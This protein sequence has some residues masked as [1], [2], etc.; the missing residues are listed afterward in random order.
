[1]E[2]YRETTTDVLIIGQ[3]AAGLRTAIELTKNEISCL[4]LSKR[5]Y[6]DAHTKWAA[7]GIN[8]ALANL[9]EEDSWEIHAADTLR[10]GQF[11]CDPL[12]VELLTKNVQER[13]KELQSWGCDFNKTDDGKINQRYFGA[14][15]YRRTCFVGDR[16]GE[17]ILE[18]LIKKAEELKIPSRVNTYITRLIIRDNKVAGAIG[19]DMESGRELVFRAK[20]VV[21]ACGGYASIYNRSTSR[22]DENTADGVGLAYEAGAVLQDMEQVQFHPTGMVTPDHMKGR[23]VSEAVRG[24]GGHLLNKD[25]ER[26]MEEYSPEKMELD[27]RDVVARAI[28]NEIKKGRGTENGGVWLDIS[29]KEADFIKERLPKLVKRFEEEGIDF[30]QEPVEVAPTSH[31][32]MGGLR[33][34]FKTGQTSVPRLYA[35]GES[36]AGVHGANR[37]GG[38]SLA[39]TVVF[40]QITGA[41]LA[42]V[43]PSLPLIKTEA[44]VI[45]E[46]FEK[47]AA[48]LGKFS[49]S[50]PK[51]LIQQIGELLWENAGIIRDPEKL[52]KGLK[53]LLEISNR[54]QETVQKKS[55]SPEERE[56]TGNLNFILKAA[57]AVFRGGLLRKESRGAHY[58]KDITEMKDEW[59]QN[60]YYHQ[61]EGEMQ[62]FTEPV[63]AIPE[64]V[65]KALEEE[66]S[67]DYHHL[68]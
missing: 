14:Q 58:R 41:H 15:S 21:L 38:N 27:A 24:E 1:M 22:T 47:T 25:K 45:R 46:H 26:F 40:G 28:F 42:Q 39:E 23:L 60:I 59:R 44:S 43:I 50:E 49:N 7:G 54:E 20:A 6:G 61:K 68:E 66:H 57:E 35:V 4:V 37:L 48:A 3:G 32:A 12:A 11:L 18:T 8:A 29:H 65:K 10:E 63:P 13:V 30:T 2:D 62:L 67:L 31:Y 34:D 56:I 36:T 53:K 9:D 17:A 51:K 5:N 55:L 64:P 52:E 33:V 19:F 16:T